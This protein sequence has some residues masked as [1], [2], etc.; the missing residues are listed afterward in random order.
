MMTAIFLSIAVVSAAFSLGNAYLFVCR[1]RG[2]KKMASF[3]SDNVNICSL[4]MAH[5]MHVSEDLKSVVADRKISPS[6]LNAVN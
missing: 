3:K 4:P 1:V 6:F 5:G 2:K